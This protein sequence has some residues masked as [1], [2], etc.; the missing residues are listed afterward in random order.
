MGLFEDRSSHLND[1]SMDQDVFRLA[2]H[3]CDVV[4]T[5][6]NAGTFNALVSNK[7]RTKQLVVSGRVLLETENEQRCHATGD[8]F[9]IEEHSDHSIHYTENSSLI[10]FWFDT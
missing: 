7:R 8:W 1:N 6:Y 9:E 4:F 3:G 10:E 5:R 2:P